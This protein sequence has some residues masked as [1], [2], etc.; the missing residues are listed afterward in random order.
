MARSDTSFPFV[1]LDPETPTAAFLQFSLTSRA[2]F[3]D[4]ASAEVPAQTFTNQIFSFGHEG[5]D[6]AA[7]YYHQQEL[8]RGQLGLILPV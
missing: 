8:G 6:L 5:A 1:W 3:S 4:A 7:L 2:L